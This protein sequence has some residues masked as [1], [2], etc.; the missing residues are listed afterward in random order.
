MSGSDKGVSDKSKRDSFDDSN[1]NE[2]EVKDTTGNREAS[3][4][5][6]LVGIISPIFVLSLPVTWSVEYFL[7]IEWNIITVPA[8]VFLSITYLVSIPSLFIDVRSVGST[9]EKLTRRIGYVTIVAHAL[10]VWGF[11]HVLSEGLMLGGMLLVL[12]YSPVWI[13]S[14]LTSILYVV[15]RVE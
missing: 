1:S 14:A 3:N 11:T 2:P 10:S 6:L 4:P 8:L 9:E 15:L 7:G 12:L 13:T 5:W